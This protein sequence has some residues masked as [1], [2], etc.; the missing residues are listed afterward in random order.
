MTMILQLTEMK[1]S[2]N[3]FFYTDLFLL[4]SSVTG[5]SFMSISLMVL[6]LKISFISDWPYN[7]K[8]PR[9]SFA[10]YLGTGASYGYKIWVGLLGKRGWLLTLHFYVKNS[11][12][13][14]IF[15]DK[16]KKI[17]NKNCK[18]L[19]KNLDTF[20]DGKFADLKRGGLAKKRGAGVF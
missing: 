10:Q 9:L 12:K 16:Q 2:S 8:Y 3:F 15:H 5:L 7:W 17:I 4:S 20:K 14:E 13:S 1:S 11:L 6:K 18:T 19:T